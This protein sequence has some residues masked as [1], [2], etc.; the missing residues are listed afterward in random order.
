MCLPDSIL[1]FHKNGVQGRSLRNGEVTQE[2]TD[3]SRT[4]KLLGSDK[5]VRVCFLFFFLQFSCCYEINLL[6]F[7]CNYFI[8]VIIQGC[9]VGSA[10]GC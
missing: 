7:F 6:L 3:N 8:F 2:I 4:Y 5:L 10:Y 1:A 9:C